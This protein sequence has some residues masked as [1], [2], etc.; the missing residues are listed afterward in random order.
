MSGTSPPQC[1]RNIPAVAIV[2][3]S[4]ITRFPKWNCIIYDYCNRRLELLGDGNPLFLQ[5]LVRIV[6]YGALDPAGFLVLVKRSF[7]VGGHNE[8]KD[9]PATFSIDRTGTGGSLGMSALGGYGTVVQMFDTLQGTSSVYQKHR[10]EFTYHLWHFVAEQ[11]NNA[12]HLLSGPTS[13]LGSL[14]WRTI[15]A[16]FKRTINYS[17]ILVRSSKFETLF[18]AITNSHV[19]H[20]IYP[21]YTIPPSD[22]ASLEPGVP[23]TVPAK[24]R[25]ESSAENRTRGPKTVNP[26]WQI[27]LLTPVPEPGPVIPPTIISSLPLPLSTSPALPPTTALNSTSPESPACESQDIGFLQLT[28]E[29]AIAPTQQTNPPPFESNAPQRASPI[30]SSL[31]RHLPTSQPQ[32]QP[33][34]LQSCSLDF[35][36]SASAGLREVGVSEAP[37]AGPTEEANK[38][39]QYYPVTGSRRMS[40]YETGLLMG[41]GTVAAVQRHRPSHPAPSTVSYSITRLPTQFVAAIQNPMWAMSS[42]S[43]ISANRMNIGSGSV[44]NV[45]EIHR[46]RYNHAITQVLPRVNLGGMSAPATHRLGTVSQFLRPRSSDPGQPLPMPRENM[47]APITGGNGMG[48]IASVG[49]GT[50]STI[51]GG[52]VEKSEKSDSHWSGTLEWPYTDPPLH[53]PAVTAEPMGNPLTPTWPNVLSLGTTSYKVPITELEKWMKEKK[54]VLV[55]FEPASKSGEHNFAQLVEQLRERECY[56]V[57]SWEIPGKGR[58]TPNLLLAPFGQGLLGAAFPVTGTPDLPPP[59]PLPPPPQQTTQLDVDP[60]FGDNMPPVSPSTLGDMGHM[61]ESALGSQANVIASRL[62]AQ[63]ISPQQVQQ[64]ELQAQQNLQ[65]APPEVQ[66]TVPGGSGADVCN[67]QDEGLSNAEFEWG[68]SLVSGDDAVRKAWDEIWEMPGLLDN[69]VTM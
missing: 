22:F 13:I 34:L 61:E 9:N 4:A 11:P 48:S 41:S 36:Q 68:A 26:P 62:P 18:S 46:Q 66:P 5:P 60:N 2:I 8:L 44:A 24:R 16:E 25:A 51:A 23:S 52:L 32:M 21:H 58:S 37:Q 14:T 67:S 6:T 40:E 30:Q 59:P 3:D 64:R 12:K 55:R 56:A 19:S 31:A 50:C 43:N 38:Y 53:A 57:A 1:S 39:P 27:N 47:Q 42:P 69:Q 28:S 45:G 29:L 20:P 63:P 49:T 33:Q 65:H 7:T 15:P 54:A 10:E 17:S 35:Y